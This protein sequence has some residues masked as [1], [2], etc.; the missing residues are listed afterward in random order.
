ME[1][2]RQHENA[3][4][5]TKKEIES[6]NDKI[7]RFENEMSDNSTQYEVSLKSERDSNKEVF[8]I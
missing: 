7:V 2:E 3:M 8:I 5:A 4:K 6:L 1:T